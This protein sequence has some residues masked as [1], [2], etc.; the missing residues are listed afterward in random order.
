[1]VT[2]IRN[3]QKTPWH[4][5]KAYLRFRLWLRGQL[6]YL[7]AEQGQGQTE[8]ALI[9]LVVVI[10]VIVILT[11][12]GLVLYKYWDDLIASLPFS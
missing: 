6:S 10:V 4:W 9:I 11:L 8:F 7:S 1:M 12:F 5:L 2:H 3:W